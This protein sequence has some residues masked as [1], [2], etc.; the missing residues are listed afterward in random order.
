[1][2][3]TKKKKASGGLKIAASPSFDLTTNINS[4]QLDKDLEEYRRQHGRSKGMD[5]RFNQNINKV[6]TMVRGA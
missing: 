3:N 4:S 6:R 2:F 1:M 5:K